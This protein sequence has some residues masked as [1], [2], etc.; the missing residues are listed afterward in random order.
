MKVIIIVGYNAATRMHELA[1]VEEENFFY[2]LTDDL[3]DGDIVFFDEK[4]D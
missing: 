3:H 4:D 2:D 1:Y